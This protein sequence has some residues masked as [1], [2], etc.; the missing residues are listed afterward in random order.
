MLFLFITVTVLTYTTFSPES[1]IVT[2]PKVHCKS[3]KLSTPFWPHLYVAKLYFGIFGHVKYDMV[4][5]ETAS[6]WPH[7]SND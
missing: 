3:I 7:V 5:T 6:L 1:S 2:Y 4:L